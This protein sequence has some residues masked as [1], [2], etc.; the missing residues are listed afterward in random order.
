[1]QVRVGP[2]GRLMAY[3]VFLRHA[4]ASPLVGAAQSPG[5][6]GFMWN[7]RGAR[8]HDPKVAWTASR[9]LRAG[10]PSNAPIRTVRLEARKAR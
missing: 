2:Q 3:P 7:A 1:M 5:R 8:E 4:P 10:V 9:T 6:A